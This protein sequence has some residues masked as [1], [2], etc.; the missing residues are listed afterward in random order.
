MK[1]C[2]CGWDGQGDHPCHAG[3]YTCGKPGTERVIAG[4]WAVLA[5][6]HPKLD[7]YVTYACDEHWKI[8]KEIADSRGK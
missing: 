2:R 5:G 3:K 8:F 6:N 7:A 1:K 4:G